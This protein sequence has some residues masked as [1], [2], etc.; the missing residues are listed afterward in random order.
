MIWRVFYYLDFGWRQY[1]S[2]FFCAPVIVAG[3][4]QDSYETS[5]VT[6]KWTASRGEEEA[7]AACM[8]WPPTLTRHAQ[9]L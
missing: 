1:D 8:C 2:C 7:H 6:E 5:Y 3:A 9:L 4:K